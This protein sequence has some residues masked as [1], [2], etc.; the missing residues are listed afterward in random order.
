MRGVVFDC[1]VRIERSAGWVAVGCVKVGVV[2]GN[3]VP[4]SGVII[5]HQVPKVQV[6]I[7]LGKILFQVVG[8][9][10]NLG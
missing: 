1:L 6:L 3:V 8:R 10:Y 4:A 9:A 7:H 5:G 2:A